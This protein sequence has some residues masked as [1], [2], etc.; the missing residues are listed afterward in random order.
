M[1][2][3]VNKFVSLDLGSV[4]DVA[5]L[6]EELKKVF[7]FPEF[8]GGNYRAL[9]DC[10]ISLRFPQDGMSK[11]VLDS[12]EDALEIEVRGLASRSDDVIRVLLSSVEAVNQGE[13]ASGL[14]PSIVLRLI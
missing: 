5:S 11:I 12:P 10:L 7:G 14:S 9:V 6:H 1:D 13:V 4:N 3:Q 8:Y 2:V